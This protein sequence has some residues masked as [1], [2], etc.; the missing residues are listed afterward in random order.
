MHSPRVSIN[1][2]AIEPSCHSDRQTLARKLID[3]RQQPQASAI[4]SASFDKVIAPLNKVIAPYV[5]APFR[6][7][8]NARPIIQ[9]QRSAGL[10]SGRHLQ[11]FP[12]P[13][14]LHPVFSHVPAGFLQQRCD[15]PVTIRAY[16]LAKM[17]MAF[18]SSSSSFAASVDT[19][20]CLAVD[21][22][23]DRR[24]VHSILVPEH[25]PRR[26]LAA[27]RWPL[28]WARGRRDVS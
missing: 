7:Q 23:S 14:A 4:V 25:A 3:H 9:P 11:A 18:V 22:L 6:P 12:P 21:R 20:V 19:A 16:S 1:V 24:A 17:M 26:T 28:P 10:L 2:I 5:I 15:A 13:D 8:S 27:R